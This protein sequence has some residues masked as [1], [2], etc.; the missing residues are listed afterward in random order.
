MFYRMFTIS[1]GYVFD[2]KST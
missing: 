2:I 1:G